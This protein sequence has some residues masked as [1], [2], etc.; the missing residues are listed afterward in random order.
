MLNILR[1]LCIKTCSIN[2][3]PGGI[4]TTDLQDLRGSSLHQTQARAFPVGVVFSFLGQGLWRGICNL[5]K[6]LAI[7][8]GL[9]PP[10]CRLEV[11][12]SIQLSY[13]TNFVF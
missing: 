13:G 1:Y 4:R 6:L 8:G 3:G 9:K 7:P 5:L 10:T 12:R 11:Y 2:G